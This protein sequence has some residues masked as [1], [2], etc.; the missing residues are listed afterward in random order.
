MKLLSFALA[1]S[2]ALFATTGCAT[3]DGAAEDGVAEQDI[4]STPDAQV[5]A[6]L[7]TASKGLF[8]SGSEGEDDPVKVYSLRL[9]K[10]ETPTPEILVERAHRRLRGLAS[11][12]DGNGEYVRGFEKSDV[13]GWFEQDPPVRENYATDAEFANAQATVAKWAE[14]KSVVESKL[15]N[16]KGYHFGWRYGADGSLETGA[17]AL[18]VVGQ[19]ASGRVVILY[20]ITIWT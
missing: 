5:L 6:E 20:G 19:T 11:E 13:D 4:V 9:R 1:A 2:L 7:R 10:G 15:T 8:V 14:F 3:S 18:T 12:E 17:V 16:L